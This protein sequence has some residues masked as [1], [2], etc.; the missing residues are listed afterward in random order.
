MS[1]MGIPPPPTGANDMMGGGL[2]VEA[3]PGI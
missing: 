3:H 1:G 2:P